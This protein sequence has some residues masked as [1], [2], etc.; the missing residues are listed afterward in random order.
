M[1][2][3]RYLA[4]CFARRTAPAVNEFAREL[5]VPQRSL[6]RWF[7][8]EAGVRIGDYFKNVQIERAKELL[9]TTDMPLTAIGDAAAFGT[10]VPPRSA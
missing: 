3:D 8:T 4:E 9:A 1:A 6:G 2:A 10:R 5:G 7:L